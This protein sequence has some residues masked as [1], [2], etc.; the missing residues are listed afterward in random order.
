M[1]YKIGDMYFKTKK[2][3]DRY[4]SHILHTT[5]LYTVIKGNDRVWLMQ[6]FQH[7]PDSHTKLNEVD[8]I[9]VIPDQWGCRCFNI[10]YKDNTTDPISKNVCIK[11]MNNKLITQQ[12][13]SYDIYG[14]F[15]GAISDQIL[16]FR[17]EMFSR[18][19]DIICPITHIILH[20]DSDTHV[21]HHFMEK[22]F[23]QIV[24]NFL[25][26]LNMTLK[27]VLISKHN[28]NVRFTTTL[29][30]PLC[31]RWGEYHRSNAKLRL[32]HKSA[33]LRGGKSVYIGDIM[34]HE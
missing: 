33:N 34:E 6:L 24:F 21:D 12:N 13:D 8:M 23:Q 19:H 30:E 17:N 7:H 15:R 31:S 27:D 32:L 5:E 16:S 18:H 28:G 9:N 10:V 25:R 1:G 4:A 2:E 29:D 22:T 26:S 20:N 3:C 11:A 14:A